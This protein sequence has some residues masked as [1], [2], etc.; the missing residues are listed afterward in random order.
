[1][2]GSNLPERLY[3]DAHNVGTRCNIQILE[4]LAGEKAEQEAFQESEVARRVS[5]EEAVARKMAVHHQTRA[6]QRADA[7][8]ELQG[9]AQAQVSLCLDLCYVN[10]E[11]CAVWT[12]K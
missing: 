9:K 8:Q 5:T 4:T 10:N 3:P 1:M 7:R 6:R 11:R 12:R 2:D